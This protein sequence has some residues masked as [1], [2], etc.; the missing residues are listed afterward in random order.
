M[1]IS[2]VRVATLCD[3]S[4]YMPTTVRLTAATANPMRATA[5]KRSVA[6]PVPRRRRTASRCPEGRTAG[7]LRAPG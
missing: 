7:E 2:G 5:M 4:P 6:N 1:P 3:S